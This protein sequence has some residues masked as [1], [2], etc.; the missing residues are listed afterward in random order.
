MKIAIVSQSYYPRTGG[1]T[2][3]VHHTAVELRNRGHDVTVVTTRYGDEP[4]ERGVE[5][6]GRNVLVPINGAWVNMTVGSNLYRDLK[7]VF[8]TLDP[9]VIHTHNAL[10]PTLPL[11]ALH[12]APRHVHVVGTFHAAADGNWAYRLFQPYL[13]RMARRLDARVAVSQ[14]AID[15]ASRYFPGNYTIVP[16]GIDCE[17]FNPDQRPIERFDDGKFNMLFVGRLDKRKGVKYL[18]NAVTL[19]SRQCDRPIRLI[20]VGD[21]GVRRR[22]LP[23]LPDEVELVFTGVVSKDILPRYFASADAFCSPATERESFGIVLLE[24]MASG[25]P[26]VGTGIPGYLTLLRNRWNALVVPPRDARSLS[27]AILEL[28]DKP[29]LCDRLRHNALGFANLYRWERIVDRLEQTYGGAEEA[30]SAGPEAVAG[31]RAGA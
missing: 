9:D 28:I 4:V 11:L 20:V 22:F 26:V 23:T 15:L 18:F 25:V 16:N 13:R 7:R 29:H 30:E 17:R 31:S 6:I 2:E 5:R 21:N 8:A 27:A 24:A 12:A 10:T 1:V 14:A 3:N 19:A